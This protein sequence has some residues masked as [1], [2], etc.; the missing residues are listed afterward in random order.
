MPNDSDIDDDPYDLDDSELRDASGKQWNVEKDRWEV[1]GE[2]ISYRVTWKETD[3]PGEFE[4]IFTDVDQT[5]DFYQSKLK[6]R[7]SYGA[8]YEHLD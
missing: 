1:N 8:A 4:R 6:G 5:Y 2:P 3:E 7:G